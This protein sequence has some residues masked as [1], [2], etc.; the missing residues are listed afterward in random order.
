MFGDLGCYIVANHQRLSV[1]VL[2]ERYA[3]TDQVGL[4]LVDRGGG[5]LGNPDAIR[6]GAV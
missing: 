5:A 6:I 4:V 3:D 1:T 2:R